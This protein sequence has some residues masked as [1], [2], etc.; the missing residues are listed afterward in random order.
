MFFYIVH[1]IHCIHI[2]SH[3]FT[4][5][6]TILG[7]SSLKRA[8]FVLACFA[9]K[10]GSSTS[11]KCVTLPKVALLESK[12]V[13]AIHFQ[14]PSFSVYSFQFKRTTCVCR[15]GGGFKPFFTCSPRN[16]ERWSNLTMLFSRVSSNHE[17]C[18]FGPRFQKPQLI[19]QPFWKTM[20]PNQLKNQNKA[21]PERHSVWRNAG[22][23]L[24]YLKSTTGSDLELLYPQG[25]D[26]ILLVIGICCFFQ[27]AGR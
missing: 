22:A 20:Q 15:L 7:F 4:H 13:L 1:Y 18:V 25:F 6:H 8:R 9:V 11:L 19:H 12:R 10:V 5:V 21:T 17:F 24:G 14:E 27:L 3:I 26:R 16:P 23:N 2:Y